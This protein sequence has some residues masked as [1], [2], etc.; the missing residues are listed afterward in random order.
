MIMAKIKT[1]GILTSGGDAP[2]MNAAIRAVT[3][4]GIYNGFKINLVE[5]TIE[6][7]N[8]IKSIIIKK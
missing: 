7:L 2:G 6:C 5:R 4:A 8:P 3:R 1:I